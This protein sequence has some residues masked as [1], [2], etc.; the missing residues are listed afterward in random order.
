MGAIKAGMALLLTKRGAGALSNDLF[1]VAEKSEQPLPVFPYRVTS[2][3][4]R[5]GLSLLFSTIQ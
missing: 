3:R 4:S 1:A 2:L 5:I